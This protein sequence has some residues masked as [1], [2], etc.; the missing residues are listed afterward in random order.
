MLSGPCITQWKEGGLMARQVCS[1]K[2]N[3][4]DNDAG[5]NPQSASIQNI[6]QH[7]DLMQTG[8]SAS[9][10]KKASTENPKCQLSQAIWTNNVACWTMRMT[11]ICSWKIL[12]HCATPLAWGGQYI[13]DVMS[14]NS[15][16]SRI[17]VL[18]LIGFC[19]HH[20]WLFCYCCCQWRCCKQCC[21]DC[22]CNSIDPASPPG[23]ATCLLLQLVY[24]ILL[25]I[26]LHSVQQLLLPCHCC[27]TQTLLPSTSWCHV[28]SWE[29]GDVNDLGRHTNNGWELCI[30]Y[31]FAWLFFFDV[32]IIVHVLLL[33]IDIVFV[34]NSSHATHPP[35]IVL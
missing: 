28:A 16:P 12:N 13:K 14:R 4:N 19:H 22:A 34:L 29:S 1:W 7:W 15:P 25:V 32:N 24:F 35:A 20:R 11:R 33:I 9:S 6:L 10:A 8:Q 3:E 2:Y 30:S 27:C 26:Q 31:C 18:V 23:N 17:A 5:Q 21:H